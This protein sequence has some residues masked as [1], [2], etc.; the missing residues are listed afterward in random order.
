MWLDWVGWI[1][2]IVGLVG[3]ACFLRF[4][5]LG[6]HKDVRGRLVTRLPGMSIF[7]F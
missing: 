5:I 3:V 7:A 4:G 1:G 2:K 6:G